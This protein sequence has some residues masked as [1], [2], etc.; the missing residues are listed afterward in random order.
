MA[1]VHLRSNGHGGS[2]ARGSWQS[3]SSSNSPCWHCS[4]VQGYGGIGGKDVADEGSK[5]DGQIMQEGVTYNVSPKPQEAKQAPYT[6]YDHFSEVA[7][8]A[9]EREY[10]RV[11]NPYPGWRRKD[12]AA[13]GWKSRATK[14]AMTREKNATR[15]YSTRQSP[16]HPTDTIYT[17]GGDSIIRK[18]WNGFWEW[19][20]RWL[21]IS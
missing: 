2:L 3:F 15:L 8:E 12:L 10:G 5:T 1:A 17:K 16:A 4:L 11:Q 19:S 14:R 21:G 7:A 18:A 20:W 9:E 13:S 6:G